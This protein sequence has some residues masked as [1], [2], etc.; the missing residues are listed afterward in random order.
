MPFQSLQKAFLISTL[1][2]CLT[3]TVSH[4]FSD[5]ERGD[6][7]YSAIQELSGKY[8]IIAGYPDG[9]FRP[10]KNITREEAAAELNQLV[11]WV[12]NHPN[13]VAVED[14]QRINQM[15]GEL[16][17]E[18]NLLQG[19]VSALR[20]DQD[21]MKT[22]LSQVEAKLDWNTK[23]RGLVHLL[24]LSS[25]K[26]LVGAGK[27]LVTVGKGALWLGT[28]GRVNLFGDLVPAPSNTTN[29]YNGDIQ[30]INGS[31]L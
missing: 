6:W 14:L 1:L 13:A 20:N 27:D 17:L 4:A 19:E 12:E 31:S 30:F 5:V 16:R 8:G 9:S 24:A 18:L 15:M 3:G 23:N 7:S 29:R 26:V 10:K 28:F 21:Q 25:G 2:A 22:Q 11:R